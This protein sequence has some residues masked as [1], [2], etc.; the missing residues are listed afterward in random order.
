MS[1]LK[2]AFLYFSQFASAKAVERFFV[3]SSGLDYEALKNET[4]DLADTFRN[5]D[6][7]DFVFGIDITAVQRR[8]SSLQGMFL[9]VDY[10][11]ITSSIDS[12]DVKTDR[13]RMSVT[14]AV[15]TPE[16]HDQAT[17]M[18]AQDRALDAI[19][20]IRRKMRDDFD[21]SAVFWMEFPT[22]VQP[23]VARPLANSIGW[24]MEFEIRAI[25]AV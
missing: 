20:A 5:P 11:T 17:E 1:L 13:F 10:S 7:K 23:I 8:V 21:E 19:S 2:K 3:L 22:S 18:L 25:D 4:L 12:V 6:I 9:F 16:D 15:P 24:S 14:V